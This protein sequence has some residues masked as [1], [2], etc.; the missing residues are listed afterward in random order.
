MMIRSDILQLLV[1]QEYEKI[2][3][4]YADEND[5]LTE[6]GT[7]HSYFSDGTVLEAN[8]INE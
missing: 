5:K 2:D 1:N 7:V 3:S 4:Y 8:L 6:A